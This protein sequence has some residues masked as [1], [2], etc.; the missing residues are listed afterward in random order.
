MDANFAAGA[1]GLALCGCI[2]F[3]IKACSEY[4]GK[5]LE[6]VKDVAG[7]GCNYVEQGNSQGGVLLCFPDVKPPAVAP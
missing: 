6:M 1:V 3:G 2:A 5:H 4:E 7:K